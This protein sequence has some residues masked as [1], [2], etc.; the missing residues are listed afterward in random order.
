LPVHF[1]SDYD[2]AADARLT[3]SAQIPVSALKPDTRRRPT[4]HELPW[5]RDRPE[6]VRRPLRSRYADSVACAMSTSS[7][8]LAADTLKLTSSV[9]G[10][11]DRSIAPARPFIRA[12][13][14]ASNAG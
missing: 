7:P 8:T 4:D 11:S 3:F 14:R 1:L 9:L 12:R 2:R 6:I 10:Q 5:D 13:L